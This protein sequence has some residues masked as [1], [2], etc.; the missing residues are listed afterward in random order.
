MQSISIYLNSIAFLEIFKNHFMALNEPPGDSC[1]RTQILG[2]LHEP[3]GGWG[4]PAKRH[5]L[6]CPVFSIFYVSVVWWCL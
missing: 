4:R 2:F 6:C 3:P 1:F 5:K